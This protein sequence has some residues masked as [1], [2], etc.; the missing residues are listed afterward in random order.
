MTASEILIHGLE[1]TFWVSLLTLMVFMLRRPVTQRFGSRAAML[2]WLAPALRLV[3]PTFQR[4]IRVVAPPLDTAPVPIETTSPTASPMPLAVEPTY[5][6]TAEVVL[7]KEAALDVS[8]LPLAASDAVSEPVLSAALPSPEMMAAFV[9]CL[10]FLGFMV[11]FA[12]CMFRARR[13]KATLLAESMPAPE[14]VA[15]MAANAADRAGTDKPFTLI[16]SGAAETP[17][18]MGLR[19]P[20]LALPTDFEER[21][22]PD[23]QEMVLLHELTHLK[24]GDLATLLASEV[25]F[26]LQWFNPLTKQARL[27]LRADQEAACDEAVRA[28]GINTKDYAALL[29]KAARMG[30]SLPALTLDHGL[31]ERIIRMQNPLGTPLK[32]TAFALLAGASAIALAGFTASRTDVTVY[33]HPEREHEE[34]ILDG[35][36]PELRAAIEAERAEEKKAKAAKKA[37]SAEEEKEARV[38]RALEELLAENRAESDE[39]ESYA[40]AKRIVRLRAIASDEAREAAEQSRRSAMEDREAAR[41]I[42]AERRR[43]TA[44]ARFTGLSAEGMDEVKLRLKGLTK[45]STPGLRRREEHVIVGPDG[46]EKRIV[47]ESTEDSNV[48]IIIDKEGERL[49]VDGNVTDLKK[50]KGKDG[51]GAMIRFFSK[52]GEESVIKQHN[53]FGPD[54]QQQRFIIQGDEDSD[55]EVFFDGN[56]KKIIIDGEEINLGSLPGQNIGNHFREFFGSNEGEASGQRNRFAFRTDEGATFDFDFDREFEFPD[57]ANIVRHITSAIAPHAPHKIRIHRDEYDE[58]MILL[59]DPFAN[60]EMPQVEPPEPPEFEFEAPKVTKKTTEEGTWILIPEEPDMSGFEAAMEV[61]EE[62]MEEF[63]ETMEE[64]GEAMGEVGEAIGDLAEECEDHREDSDKPVI[65]RESISVGDGEVRAVC[66]SGGMERFASA[67][68]TE[69]LKKKGLSKDEWAHFKDSI[70]DR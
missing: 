17:Q 3:V 23:E 35:L 36:S 14:P 20:L 16:M 29:L 10:W 56:E 42:E 61:F 32:R 25:G 40:K 21:Y 65:L 34:D 7:P 13:W 1:T 59:S 31:K 37:L 19:Q 55:V 15:T 18:I 60:L 33:E 62:A 9:L 46:E 24:R 38:A 47:I 57:G 6:P 51:E 44:G 58:G 26:A 68:M 5:V 50:L 41:A 53:I 30:R 67:E 8:P 45:E 52:D 66:A 39:Q 22:R 70:D 69:F 12:L 2:L 43:A 48:E 28:L 64:W 49:I 4:E 27:A 11:T 54:G 63:G